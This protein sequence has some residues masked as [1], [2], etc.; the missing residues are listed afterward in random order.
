MKKAP[1]DTEMKLFP[2]RRRLLLLLTATIAIMI[3]AFL[4]GRG[5]PLEV[6]A[7]APR[8]TVTIETGESVDLGSF[9][10]KGPVLVYF[11]PKSD[12]PGCT[13]QAC[14]LRDHFAEIKDSGIAV[15]G[16]ST[17]SVEAQKRFQDNH[18]LPFS[19]VAD[20]E[21]KLGQAFGVGNAFL[22][23]FSRQSFL[24]VDG[25]IAW[26]DLSASPASQAQDALE[27]YRN[28]AAE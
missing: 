12:T 6:G 28:K 14:N 19:L 15:F 11:Y 8:L 18:N 1:H 24:V 17:D 16:V 22:G 10:D 13:R 27:A 2:P 3:P 7:P 26:R 21:R 4:F 5:D 20:T 9:Y 25:K 23:F